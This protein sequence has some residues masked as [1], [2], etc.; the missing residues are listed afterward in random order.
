MLS[1][2]ETL[3]TITCRVEDSPLAL[4]YL[5]DQRPCKSS[6]GL[7]LVPVPADLACSAIPKC[8]ILTRIVMM[9]PGLTRCKIP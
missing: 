4:V 3:V 6:G 5:S 7:S 1:R 8:D 2:N 9:L